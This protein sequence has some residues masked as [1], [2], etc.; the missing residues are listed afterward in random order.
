[1][2][3]KIYSERRTVNDIQKVF[4]NWKGKSGKNNNTYETTILVP[5]EL[6]GTKSNFGIKGTLRPIYEPHRAQIVMDCN[7]L[8]LIII[9]MIPALL[10]TSMMFLTSSIIGCILSFLFA[11]GFTFFFLYHKIVKWGQLYLSELITKNQ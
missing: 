6:S 10:I 7:P 3:L 8:K 4:D 5:Y 2:L 11:Y 1:M 9:P